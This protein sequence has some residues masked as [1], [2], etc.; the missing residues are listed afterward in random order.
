MR[1]VLAIFGC[2]SLA[3]IFSGCGAQEG[4]TSTPS[5]ASDL[6]AAPANRLT[7]AQEEAVIGSIDD[8]CSDA[9]CEGELDFD[10]RTLKCDFAKSQCVLALTVVAKVKGKHKKFQRQCVLAQIGSFAG[11]MQTFPNGFQDLTKE[12]LDKIDKC[13]AE[14]SNG[15]PTE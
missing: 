4:E 7:D 10:S 5:S 14:A 12:F 13:Y 15:I 2:C 9:Q 1:S 11:I 3:A 6:T 8:H